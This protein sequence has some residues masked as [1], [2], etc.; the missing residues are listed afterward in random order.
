MNGQSTNQTDLEDENEQVCP[1]C[2]KQGS[3]GRGH[4]KRE[5]ERVT[6]DGPQNVCQAWYIFG[7]WNCGTEF[8][9]KTG[10]EAA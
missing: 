4:M 8:A 10:E 2:A 6:D 5:F 7:C 1:N 9:V 3:D